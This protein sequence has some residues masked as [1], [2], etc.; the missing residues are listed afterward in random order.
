MYYEELFSTSRYV[1]IDS[2]FGV[3]KWFI[4]VRKKVILACAF[5]KKSRYWPSMV[6]GKEMEDHFGVV[7]GEEKYAI[8]G[9]VEDVI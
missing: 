7:E 1:I 5:I 4:K 6:T 9:T 3:L 8:Q 2:S